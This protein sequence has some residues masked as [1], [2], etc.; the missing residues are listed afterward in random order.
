MSRKPAITMASPTNRVINLPISLPAVILATLITAFAVLRV[1]Y[2]TTYSLWGGEAFS[3]LGVKQDWNAMFAYIIA[4]IV[5]PPL[6]YVFLKLWILVGGE[7]LF[8]LK[9]FPVLNGIAMVVPL[10][11]LCRE[12]NLRLPVVNLALLLI[13]LNGYLIHYAQE[14]RMYSM[15]AFL[16]LCSFWLFIRFFKAA[17]NDIQSLIMLTAVNLLTI[18]THYYGWLV[19]GLE[20][21]FLILWRRKILVFGSSIVLLLLLFSPW[22]YLVIQAARSIGGLEKNLDWIPKPRLTDILHF[23]S[24]LNGASG[25]RYI[26]LLGLL[27]FNL[28]LLPWFVGILRARRQGSTEDDA[29]LFSWLAML[30][31]LPVLVIFLVSQKLEQAVWID[32]YFIFIAAPYMLLVAAAVYRLEPKWIRNIYIFLIILW[33]ALAGINDLRT[34]RVAWT[35]AQLGSRIN[36]ESLTIQMEQAEPASEYPVI[37]YTADVASRGVAVGYWTIVTSLDYYLDLHNDTRFEMVAARNNK[38]LI[39][40]IEEDHFWVAYFDIVGWTE[41]TPKVALERN[42]FRV[43]DE[44]AYNVHGNRFVLLPVWKK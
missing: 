4:D 40:Q 39:N 13:A 15:F 27:L 33:G 23:Y 3:M 22:A 12:L 38:A 16:A 14:L 6:F 11:L 21:L 25:S 35:G 31:F 24:T 42:G 43:G 7:S 17:D 37:V 1:W 5:H 41:P 29:I 2:M 20:L 34:N 9:L 30:S 18:Y 26:E 44:I 36:W 8:W 10:L 28:P 32:R 19:V